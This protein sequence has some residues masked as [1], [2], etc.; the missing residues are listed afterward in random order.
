MP[1][2]KI[3][4]FSNCGSAAEARRIARELVKRRLVACANVPSAP[5]ESIYR[6]K[7]KVEKAKE[8]LLIAKTSKARFKAVER[9]IRELHSYDVPEIIAV[10]IAAGSA[11]Y[12]AW[13]E[14][15]VR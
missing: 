11:E 15:N 9:A 10:A 4:V 2:A 3:V 6:W 7:G 12:L 1:T 13:I 5:V 8:F 14:R